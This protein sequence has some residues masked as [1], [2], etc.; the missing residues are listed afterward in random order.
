MTEKLARS[1]YLFLAMTLFTVAPT[2]VVSVRDELHNNQVD[3]VI[4]PEVGG[5][6]LFSVDKHDYAKSIAAGE[7]AAGE[8]LSEIRRLIGQAVYQSSEST[9]D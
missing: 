1:L 4:A 9:D 2:K 3:L 7:A 6:S 5:I 8:S